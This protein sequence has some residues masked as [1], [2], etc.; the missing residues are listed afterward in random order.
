MVQTWSDPFIISRDMFRTRCHECVSS[1]SRGNSLNFP[2][3]SKG[4]DDL[5]LTR[6]QLSLA[7]LARR[8]FVIDAN[9]T[10][11]LWLGV[12][13]EADKVLGEVSRWPSHKTCAI[14]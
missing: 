13:Y 11:A 14:S 12:K 5:A 3:E 9:G 6:C 4:R 8:R 7:A 1:P 10:E 2:L